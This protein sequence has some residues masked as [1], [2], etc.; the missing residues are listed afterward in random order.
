MKTKTRNRTL[1]PRLSKHRRAGFTL[2]EM[3]LVL[4]IIGLILGS[5]IFL[6]VGSMRRAKIR[7]SGFRI[8]AI[9]TA[10]T[11]YQNDNLRY[12]SGNQGLRALLERPSSGIAPRNWLGPYV[13]NEESLLDAFGNE[14]YYR[15]PSVKS[16]D[17]YDIYSPG[18]DGQPD[19]EDDIGN[20]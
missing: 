11:E 17:D 2:M 14:F 9:E 8:K 12:P 13:R 20:W 18:P 5:G 16:A 6:L 19:T 7:T 10:L 15:M 3:V 1:K 4:G